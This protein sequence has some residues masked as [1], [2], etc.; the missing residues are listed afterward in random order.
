MVL[1]ASSKTLRL[2]LILSIYKMDTFH[3]ACLRGKELVCYDCRK[4]IMFGEIVVAKR[5]GHHGPHKLRHAKCAIRI[6][7]VTREQVEAALAN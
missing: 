2:P 4:D 6:H 7:I 5:A 1:T 3:T